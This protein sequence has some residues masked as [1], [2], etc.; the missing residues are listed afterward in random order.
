MVKYSLLNVKKRWSSCCG[1]LIWNALVKDPEVKRRGIFWDA[2][3]QCAKLFSSWN[4]C[5]NTTIKVLNEKLLKRTVL[6]NILV[7]WNYEMLAGIVDIRDIS[8][9]L[10]H[11][12]IFTTIIIKNIYPA[13]HNGIADLWLDMKI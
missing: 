1:K 10:L 2:T 6:L 13:T 4:S 12:K 7:I 3:C 9:T 5:T 11:Y 8:K